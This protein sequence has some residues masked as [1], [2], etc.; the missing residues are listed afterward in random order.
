MFIAY[1]DIPKLS[2]YL[3]KRTYHALFF[4][5]DLWFIAVFVSTYI[6]HKYYKSADAAYFFNFQ[7]L[8]DVADVPEL[9]YDNHR[10]YI[11]ISISIFLRGF[12]RSHCFPP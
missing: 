8:V 6:L 2:L 1:P 7:I 11:A 4:F 10:Y 3:K 5:I 9:V 12:S